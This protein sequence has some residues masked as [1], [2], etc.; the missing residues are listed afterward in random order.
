MAGSD[1]KAVLN[2][3]TDGMRELHAEDQRMARVLTRVRSS[4]KVETEDFEA[5]VDAQRVSLRVPANAL[6]MLAGMIE[7]SAAASGGR[8]GGTTEQ[9]AH[10]SSL[11]FLRGLLRR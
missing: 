1:L 5:L 6:L 9:P 8:A 3:I 4:R 11:R 10:H 7:Q 2:Y